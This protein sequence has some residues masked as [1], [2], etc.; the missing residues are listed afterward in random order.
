MR[1]THALGVVVVATGCAEEPKAPLARVDLRVALGADAVDP[2][3]VAIAP[4]GGRFV[5]DRAL[6]LYQ[7]TESGAVAVVPM[8]ALP[9]PGIELKLPFTD[10]TAIS[11]GVF[12]LTAIG[13]GFLLDT[14]AMTLTQ[15]FCYLPTGLPADYTQHT[16]AIAY[17]AE[18]ERLYAQPVTFD[19]EGVL[20]W[21]QVASYSRDTGDSIEWYSVDAQVAATAMVI[22]PGAGL[23]LGQGAQ[24]AGVDLTTGQRMPLDSLERFGIQSIDGLA[25]D[26]AR[27]TLIVVD[28][29]SDELVE[30]ELASLTL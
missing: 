20:Q 14:A 3:G 16:D 4:D 6:G 7:I 28:S 27:G 29:T 1:M 10:I 5:F 11:P 17:D 24:L 25:V 15:H 13:D 21:S 8:S 18:L 26:R 12:A 22:V 9:D 2:V 30:I 23:V 19:A